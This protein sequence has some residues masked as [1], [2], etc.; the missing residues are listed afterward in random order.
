MRF[1]LRMKAVLAIRDER[2][3]GQ[4]ATPSQTRVPQF[5]QKG[6]PSANLAPQFLQKMR[7]VGG[8]DLL[9]LGTD[10]LPG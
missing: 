2:S 4:A 9:R 3:N 8:H 5:V 1:D 6:D 7:P 10:R